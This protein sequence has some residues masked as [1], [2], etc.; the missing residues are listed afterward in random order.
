MGKSIR[1][2]P[3]LSG[4]CRRP[5]ECLEVPLHVLR[6]RRRY[7]SRTFRDGQSPDAYD[8]LYQLSFSYNYIVISGPVIGW[9]CQ[10][11][12]HVHQLMVTNYKYNNYLH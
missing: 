10:G 4:V 11:W 5:W 1:I 6:K 9:M 2:H 12:F 8:Q 3:L 7:V